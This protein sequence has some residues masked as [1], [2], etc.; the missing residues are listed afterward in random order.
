MPLLNIAELEAMNITELAVLAK[1]YEINS[2]KKLKKKELIFKLLEAQTKQNGLI[3]S[4]GVLE[5]LP[6]GYGFLRTYNYMV[7]LL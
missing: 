1:E 5:I 2:Y 4:Q 7:F 3:F 6:D